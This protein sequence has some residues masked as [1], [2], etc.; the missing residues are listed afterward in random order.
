MDNR[1]HFRRSIALLTFLAVLSTPISAARLGKLQAFLTKRALLNSYSTALQ[2]GGPFAVEEIPPATPAGAPAVAP[3]EAVSGEADVI[4]LPATDPALLTSDDG[5]SRRLLQRPRAAGVAPSM[6]NAPAAE[7]PMETGVVRNAA[8]RE[9]TR[10][11]VWPSFQQVLAPAESV[12]AEAAPA[13]AASFDCQSL[14]GLKMFPVVRAKPHAHALPTAASA[15]APAAHKRAHAPAPI[16]PFRPATSRF[17]MAPAKL[18]KTVARTI[19]VRPIGV[20]AN[21]FSKSLMHA[22]EEEGTQEPAPAA[23]AAAHAGPGELAVAGSGAP[24]ERSSQQRRL[25]EVMLDPVENGDLDVVNLLNSL[26]VPLSA[27][28]VATT[29]PFADGGDAPGPEIAQTV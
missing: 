15:P 23:A 11:L 3:G 2:S 28:L 12:P 24:E 19:S 26:G 14:R 16:N 6:A 25:R 18:A 20:Y 21:R 29:K 22:P 5:G 7:A 4:R 10:E 8:V 17:P 1:I 9:A 27:E 13:P